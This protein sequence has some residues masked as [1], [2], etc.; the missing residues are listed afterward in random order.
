MRQAGVI[1]AAGVYAFEHN[2]ERLAEDHANA[3]ILEQAIFHTPGLDM[4]R[5]PVETNIVIFS[6]AGTGMTAR[7]FAAKVLAEH[8]VR[9]SPYIEEHLVRAV[10]HLDVHVALRIAKPPPRRLTSQSLWKR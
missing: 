10:T 4:M 2:V 8:D 7:E 6:V 3:R 1:A 9:V 5:T